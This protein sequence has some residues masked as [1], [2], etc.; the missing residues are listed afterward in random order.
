MHYSVRRPV[1]SLL[2]STL[3]RVVRAVLQNTKFIDNMGNSLSVWFDNQLNKIN[4][5]K[6]CICNYVNY[7]NT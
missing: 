4:R 7:I 2:L 1:Y 5:L 3:V 6:I